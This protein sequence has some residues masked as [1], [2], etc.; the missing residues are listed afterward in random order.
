MFDIKIKLFPGITANIK[1]T[2]AAAEHTSKKTALDKYYIDSDN[3]FKEIIGY[4]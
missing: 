2:I 4:R 3:K 1:L